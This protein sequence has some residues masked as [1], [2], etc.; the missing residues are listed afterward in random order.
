[1]KKTILISF[2][3]GRTS[4]F[5]TKWI[6]ESDKYKDYKKVV[7]FANTGKERPETLDFVNEWDNRWDFN[8]V[9]IESIINKER[10]VGSMYKIVDY[11]TAE[12]TGKIF[13]EMIDVYGIPNI[14]YPHCTREL[15]IIPIHKFM[16]TICKEYETAIGIRADEQHRVNW[17]HAKEN[18]YIYPLI[19]E[20]RVNNMYIRKFWEAQ[21]FDLKLKDYEGNCDMCWKKANRKLYT[22]INAKPELLDW[23][24]EQEIKQG[25]HHFFRGNRSAQELIEDSKKPFNKVIDKLD[26]HNMQ[27]PMFDFNLDQEESC[28]CG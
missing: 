8:V 28:F 20:V 15:K 3:G 13:E 27:K 17:K 1:M 25:E 16:K 5:M 10:G 7:V 4:A 6:M 22:L 9:W 12:R 23:W 21:C 26:L 14:S 24:N 2:S 19:T 18:N 11:E